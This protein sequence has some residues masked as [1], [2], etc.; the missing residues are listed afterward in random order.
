M[1]QSL[2]KRFLKARLAFEAAQKMGCLPND[3]AAR[4]HWLETDRRLRARKAMVDS[5]R[6]GVVTCEVARGAD[7]PAQPTLWFREGDMA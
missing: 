2:A 1:A 7:E 5:S 4:L 3:A 6:R